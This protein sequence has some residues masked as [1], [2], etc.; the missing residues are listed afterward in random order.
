[1]SPEATPVHDEARG[2]HDRHAATL[3]LQEPEREDFA[4]ELARPHPARLRELLEGL[5]DPA[6]PVPNR[7][8]ARALEI[9]FPA[10]VDPDS[11]QLRAAAATLGCELVSVGEALRAWLLVGAMA[12]GLVPEGAVAPP[13][14]AT[15]PAAVTQVIE[16]EPLGPSEAPTV[17]VEDGESWLEAL[18]DP[19]TQV[20]EPAA[21]E[22]QE[23]R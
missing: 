1:V 6:G 20:I 22:T 3:T 11:E 5:A 9:L 13:A 2:H 23:I 4:A 17:V 7:E 15:E 16:P 21:A 14:E 8:A 10:G 18:T 12:Q 19:D